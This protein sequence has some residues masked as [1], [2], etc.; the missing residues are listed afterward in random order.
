M[1]ELSRLIGVFFY[2]YTR[3]VAVFKATKGHDKPQYRC[4]FLIYAPGASAVPSSGMIKEAN[5][6]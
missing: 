4:Q 6:Q 5:Y 1:N 2:S 3:G